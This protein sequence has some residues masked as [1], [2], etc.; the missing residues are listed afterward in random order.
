M[1][2]RETEKQREVLLK[3]SDNLEREIGKQ[4]TGTQKKRQRE[5]V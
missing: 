3:S 5:S 1:R 4:D 2:D